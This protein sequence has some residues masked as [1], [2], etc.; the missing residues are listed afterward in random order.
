MAEQKKTWEMSYSEIFDAW[1][2]KFAFGAK[3]ELTLAE[4]RQVHRKWKK[5]GVL[6]SKNLI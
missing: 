5:L 2:A 1:N 4:A 3:G 6:A